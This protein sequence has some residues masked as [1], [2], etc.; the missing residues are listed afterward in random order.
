MS[1]SEGVGDDSEGEK[2]GGRREKIRMRC[3]EAERVERR[4]RE[5]MRP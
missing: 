2:K 5:K 3:G 1:A 4:M